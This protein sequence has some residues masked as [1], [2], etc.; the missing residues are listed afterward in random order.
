MGSFALPDEA[1]QLVTRVIDLSLED[2]HGRAVRADELHRHFRESGRITYVWA[3]TGEMKFSGLDY[4]R[5]HAR[6]LCQ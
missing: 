1:V 2:L 5:Q 6:G 3:D 4:A